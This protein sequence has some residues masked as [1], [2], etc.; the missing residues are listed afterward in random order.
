MIEGV[1]GMVVLILLIRLPVRWLT[2][3]DILDMLND[4]RR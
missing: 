4:W 2:G 3:V 1:L